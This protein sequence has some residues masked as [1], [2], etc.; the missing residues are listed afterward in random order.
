M[1][2]W[3]KWITIFVLLIICF[4][5]IIFAISIGAKNIPF[6]T[7]WTSIFQYNSEDNLHQIIYEVRLPR[8]L[9]AVFVGAAFAVAGTV[10]Q[11]IT[12]NPLADIGILGINGGAVLLVTIC[13]AFYPAISYGWL[14]FFS[15]IGA[16]L[17]TFLVFSIGIVAR[18]NLSL[19]TFTIAGAVIAAF[20]HAISSGI[21]IYFDLNQE[22]AFWYAGGVAGVTW[23]QLPLLIT[24]VIV[25][26][27]IATLLGKQLTILSTGQEM[28]SSLG[29]NIK[30]LLF[31]SMGV[32]VL[33]GGVGVAVGGSISFV[34][35]II[36]HLSR[37]FVGHDYRWNIPVS[38]LL[39]STLVV[40][41][42]LSARIIFAPKE[43]ALGILIA[44]IGVPFFLVVAKK[45][46]GT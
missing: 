31:T 44:F 36:P 41:A 26:I 38:A 1:T 33:L 43:L 18:R 17:S 27:I 32:I 28:A 10:I 8:V 45:L 20:L 35:L 25:S 15:F 46:E 24:I 21:A 40:I 5:S 3:H 6:I 7:V 29:I 22:L 13:F 16:A 37:K 42:D 23:K 12:R 19:F 14:T 4:A 39:G 2:I 30:F 9:G 11:A 34:G